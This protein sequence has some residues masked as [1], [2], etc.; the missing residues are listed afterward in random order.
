MTGIQEVYF[1]VLE[2]FSVSFGTGDG[3]DEISLPP[4]HQRWGLVLTESRCELR[5]ERTNTARRTNDE[6]LAPWSESIIESAVIAAV[7]SAAATSSDT[8]SGSLA[9]VAVS[10]TTQ[11]SA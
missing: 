3:K 6:H 9:T 4:D 1:D 10:G 2:I 7:G 11:Y 8:E 5:R